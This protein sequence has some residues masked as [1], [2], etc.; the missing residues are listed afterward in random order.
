MQTNNGMF[1]VKQSEDDIC[2]A[3]MQ[4]VTLHPQLKRKVIHVPNEGRRSVAYG[5]RLKA[6]GMLPGVS[7]FIIFL[8]RHDFHGACIE[9]KTIGGKPTVNQIDFINSVIQDC[10]F[11]QFVYGIDDALEVID[12]YCLKPSGHPYPVSKSNGYKINNFF[13]AC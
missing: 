12:W 1:H 2:K 3:I 6:M 13:T 11:G 7:D 10:Y 4:F 8:P 5:A 9:V